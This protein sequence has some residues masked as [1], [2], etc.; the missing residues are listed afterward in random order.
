MPEWSRCWVLEDGTPT[1]PV[2]EGFKE[3]RPAGID[4]R[5]RDLF[6]AWK[7]VVELICDDCGMDER[8]VVTNDRPVNN[9]LN[10]MVLAGR[11]QHRSGWGS[12]H[13]MVEVEPGW[14]EPKTWRLCPECL[15]QVDGAMEAGDGL[16]KRVRHR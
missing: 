11:Q 4:S 13:V 5:G 16:P 2:A 9:P 8:L 10:G 1:V 12:R 6:P 3:G 7:T 15:A 14:E